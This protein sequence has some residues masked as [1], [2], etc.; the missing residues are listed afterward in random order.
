MEATRIAWARWE[1]ALACL[2][3]VAPPLA[4]LVALVL[5]VARRDR[6]E[7]LRVDR[8]TW[9]TWTAIAALGIA[10]VAVAGFS[11]HTVTGFAGM[12]ALLWL[13]MVGHL[14]VDDRQRFVVNLGRSIAI[15]AVMA[16]AVALTG[17]SV[18]LRWG[19]VRLDVMSPANKGTVLGLGGNGLGPLLVFGAAL[20]LG[21]VL[22]A[23]G[24]AMRLEG[25]AA[26]AV[27]VA[28]PLGL[29]VRN[30][31]WGA[32]VVAASSAPQ[33][34]ALGLAVVGV[35]ALV[36]VWIEPSLLHRLLALQ[37]LQTEKER[38]SIW[39]SALAMIRDHPALG[40]GPNQFA[41]AHG[42]YLLQPS[43]HLSDPH[44]IY[45]R[46]ASEWGIP[47]AVLLFG[48]LLAWPVRMWQKRREAWRWSVLAGLLGFLA[49]GIFDT[50]LFT[51]HISAPVMVALG[52]ATATGGT[53]GGQRA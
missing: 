4:L 7:R 14:L 27:A 30:A 50:P 25:L 3:P 12:A 23:R 26:A 29:G 19:D 42:H 35:A 8:F 47:A 28:A 34:G 52:V 43:A 37:Y 21:R 41:Q 38:L 13:W 17:V 33:V 11:L 18:D 9:W 48:W 2:L 40:V 10:S 46:V 53:E 49:M 31:L 5:T 1:Q 51:F 45:L 22:E 6:L 44:S 32:L 39:Q 16:L 15:V 24:T 20:A 36:A